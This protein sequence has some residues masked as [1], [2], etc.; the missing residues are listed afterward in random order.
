VQLNGGTVTIGAS[1]L[2]GARIEV[3]LPPT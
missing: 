3:R 2:G 1:A